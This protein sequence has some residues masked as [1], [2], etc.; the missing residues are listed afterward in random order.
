VDAAPKTLVDYETKSGSCP[1]R[2]WLDELDHTVVARIEARLKRV[3]LGN[4][5]DVKAVGQG[6]SELRLKFGSGY[7][8]YFSQHGEEII[9]LLCGGD[10]GSQADDI[11]T[12]KNYWA[13]FKRRNNA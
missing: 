3:A 11:E 13:D 12:A 1:L 6:V 10:K 7:R 2:E 9:V 4:F 5:G 8:L